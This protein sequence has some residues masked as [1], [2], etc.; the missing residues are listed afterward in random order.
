LKKKFHIT[1]FFFFPSRIFHIAIERLFLDK[2]PSKNFYSISN[3]FLKKINKKSLI[4]I[5]AGIGTDA[6]FEATIIKKFDIKKLIAIDPSQIGKKTI[7]KIK[8]K[9]IYFENKALYIHNKKIKAFVPFE[10]DNTNLNL[11]IDNLYNTSES[12]LLKSVN[13]KKLLKIYKI[14]KID[15]LK[16]DIEGVADKVIKDCIKNT[17]LPEQITFELERPYS[18]LKQIDFFKRFINL[19]IILKSSYKVYY[20]GTEKLGFRS[21]ILAVLK[22]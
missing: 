2:I 13:L 12:I 20:T 9:K 15:I 5:S 3:Y 16:L 19:I 8:S 18:L 10:G 14:K 4:V 7:K 11:S 1:L 17:Y 21:E 6:S 22:K